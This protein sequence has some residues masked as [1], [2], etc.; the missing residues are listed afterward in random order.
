MGLLGLAT[1][2]SRSQKRTEKG[3]TILPDHKPQGDPK[4]G[5][6]RAGARREKGGGTKDQKAKDR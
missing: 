2:T 4:M 1:K 6:H 5:S 3:D